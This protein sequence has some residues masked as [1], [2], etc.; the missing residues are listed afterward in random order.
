MSI[1]FKKLLPA[2]SVLALAACGGG[3]SVATTPHL[4]ALT[5]S[6]GTLNPTF[7]PAVTSYSATVPFGTLSVTVTATSSSTMTISQD[8]AAAAPL[9]S[10]AA[11]AAMTVPAL[12]TQSMIT[13]AVGTS[14]KYTIQLVE[15]NDATATL[16]A[17][18]PSV[19][20]LSPAF[21][22]NTGSYGMTVPNG[23]TALKLTPTATDA[24]KT[25]SI[26]QDGGTAST[27][28]SGKA[29]A[30]LK[31]P[32]L[33]ATSTIVITVTAQNGIT[34]QAYSITLTQAGNGDASLASLR[35]SA[36]TFTP[37]FA[38]GTTAYTLTVP[39]GA[40]TVTLTPTANNTT[41][42]SI[43]LTQAGGSSQTVANGAA[44][45][46]IAVPP[47]G[48]TVNLSLAVTAQDGSSVV[49]YSIALKQQPSVDA[50][51]SA[52]TVSAGALSPVF[53]ASTFAYSVS[54]PFGTS[55]ITVTPTA[56]DTNHKSITVSQDG[57]AAVAINSGAASA[58]LPVPAPGTTTAIAIVVTAQDGTTTSTYTV[59]VTQQSGADA[60]L[61][62]LTL[63]A[64][65]LAP[66]FA[67][68]THAYTAVLP[69]GTA[70]LTVT[71]TA[72]NALAHSITVSQDGGAAATAVSG[73]ASAALTV[74]AVGGT[75]T[76]SV[77]V[78]SQDQVNTI[79]Y[80]VVISQAASTDSTLSSLVLSDGAL[81]PAFSSAVISYDVTVTSSNTGLTVTPTASDSAARSI[82]ISQ[83]GGAAATVASGTASAPFTIPAAGTPT[84]LRIT[85]TAQ[86]GATTT[87]QV[88]VNRAAATD[89]ALGSLT[90]S[91]GTLTPAF[92]S[93]TLT[94]SV[95]VPFSTATVTLTPTADS[96]A[97]QSIQVS[98]GG[99]PATTVASGTASP[100]LTV[101]GNVSIGV[102]AEDGTTRLTYTVALT[103]AAADADSALAS[104][105]PS[106]G[107][108]APAFV[109]N[110]LSYTLS[111]PFETP[112]LQLTPTADAADLQSIT[113]SQDGGA[114]VTVASGTASTA[115]T[116]PGVGIPTVFGIVVTAQ[117]GDT[118]TYQVTATRAAQ[119]VA[120]IAVSVNGIPVAGP[121]DF[122]SVQT[123]ANSSVTFTIT[124]SGN[125]DLSIASTAT[126]GDFSVTASPAPT[127]AAGGGTTALTVRF[128]PA[129][130]GLRTGTVTIA[131]SS[132]NQPSFV[133]NLTGTGIQLVTSITVT[134]PGNTIS[135]PGG[136]L[137]LTA[138]VSP[139][140]AAQAV[141]WSSATPSVATVD[142]NGLVMAVSSGTSVITATATDGSGV[143][144]SLT[145]TVSLPQT[146]N[147]VFVKQANGTTSAALSN[148]V[149][150]VSSAF[151]TSGNAFK[152][153]SPNFYGTAANGFVALPTALTG[154]FTMSA[155]IT[156][157]TANKVN[158]AC[159]VGLGITTGFTPTDRYAYMLMATSGP[160]VA[161]F[162]SNA[163]TVGAGS[164][165]VTFAIGAPQQVVFN[166]VG[167]NLTYGIVGGTALNT[168][169]VNN[170]TDGTTVYASGPVFPAISFNNVVATV[171]SLLIK[172]GSGNVLFDSS[173]GTL[174]PFAPA[175]LALSA[176]A[177]SVTKGASATVTAT[178]KAPGGAITSVTA[179][180]ADSSVVDVQVANNATGSVITLNGLKGGNTNV[181]VT[182]TSDTNVA[183]NTQTLNVTVNEFSSVDSY[184]SIAGLVYP[185]P[186]ATAAY[187]E[188][189]LSITFDSPPTLNPGGT[190]GIYK[191][192]EGSL[193]DSI[194]YAN[195]TQ[196]V[197]GV[198]MVVGSQ[199]A[200]VSGNTVFFTPHFGKLAFGTSYYV[201]IPTT[202]ISG[203][204]KGQAFAGFSNAQSVA[205]WNFTT[206]AAPVL[207]T[208]INVDGSQAATP[209]FRTVG[210]ALM[211]LA[212]NP[213]AGA[214]AIKIN[215]AAG[216]YV[217]LVNYRATS[218]PNLTITIN[219]PAGNNRGDNTIIQYTNG[220]NLNAQ[221][222][223]ASFYFAGAN[224]VLQNLTLKNT[225]TRAAV[226]QAETL[227]FDS[228]AGF[229][230][231]ANNC[232]F[233]SFQD[234]I[235]TSGRAWFYNCFIEGNTDFIWGI[236]DANLIEGS[237]LRVINDSPG[238]TYSIFVAR[239]GTPGA[240]TIGK[241]YVLLNSTVSVDSGILCSYG[242]DAGTG[243]FFDQ[244]ALV[245][246]TFTGSGTLAPGLWVTSTAP[247]SLG[248]STYVGW[249]ASGN[250]GLGAETA[251]TATGTAATINS[252]ASE[253]D[254]RDH[255][256]NRVVTVTGGTTPVGYQAA[257]TIWDLSALAA[258]FGAP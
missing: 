151:S 210:G 171:T 73:H 94:Y 234:T 242:R 33:G 170:F 237:S 166:R 137:Q 162:V 164:P 222:G 107:A 12:G 2:V 75:S 78:V 110:T 233:S 229:T 209:D 196:T 32:A 202:A 37:A 30:T 225:G 50:A 203:T 17:L 193:V 219:G 20:T 81:R 216:T 123:G 179:V 258:A 58:A 77:T 64:G 148:G 99:G 115:F 34:T 36:G 159:G 52:L 116:V 223:R 165:S 154:D 96:P 182:N 246:N 92:A 239:T 83:D 205:T 200:R 14:G 40:S 101:P 251:T 248:D 173:T 189:E 22:A 112:S 149:I 114:A 70:S 144:G 146:T 91:A 63:S 155:T 134:A 217:E 214:T 89:A 220:G 226:A 16:A 138:T 69:H 230:M 1:W 152:F 241:G 38:S 257:A 184:G 57:G 252:L 142:G 195:E 125:A 85:V 168:A 42:K 90:V 24:V 65:T 46:A 140:G 56:H 62:S 130:A 23:T 235:Q 181:T 201:A 98:Q 178:A 187:N 88:T 28:T 55:S 3:S 197:A 122:G 249:K 31:I 95:A 72:T 80:S 60:T 15:A 188:G 97:A 49:T 4:D 128:A 86:S 113:I 175:S 160:A 19:G 104:L 224:L 120:N 163:T 48:T 29:S 194:A 71:P 218:N 145:V 244:V 35:A 207:G 109:G 118:T 8:A 153:V 133:V 198:S 227:Y 5:V 247:L 256:L 129:A 190:I 132:S 208:T 45:A 9:A 136:T 180:A 236:A 232:S 243:S 176:S 177:A 53:G 21:D 121:V 141:T 139:A 51:L 68:A 87:Y 117:S 156:L 157:T 41:V 213:I 26:A 191:S 185:A 105:T 250:S 47:V 11:S 158:T 82:G 167:T 240:A 186:G 6:A 135:T 124:N 111:V 206:K 131:N 79:T 143:F 74:P 39:T 183:T 18:V 211:F 54:V 100:A 147:M 102:T 212:A 10:G 76:I 7:D 25:I 228:R 255:I 27:V 215:V 231:A 66:V 172:D 106:V 93:G 13:I 161:R 108:L 61:A 127:V 59:S 204:F 119:L 84:I 174:Q 254:T 150:T 253:Y 245:N 169:G 192:S 199:L 67:G 238:N 43:V 126:T 221:N 44:S 103:R